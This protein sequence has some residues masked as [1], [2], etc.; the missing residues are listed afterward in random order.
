MLKAQL[1]GHMTTFFCKIKSKIKDLREQRGPLRSDYVNDE[2]M[3]LKNIMDWLEVPLNRMPDKRRHPVTG[4]NDLGDCE[5]ATREHKDSTNIM[6]IG[7]N[8]LTKKLHMEI[9]GNVTGGDPFMEHLSGAVQ[10]RLEE[11]KYK[12]QGIQPR[13][14][15]TASSRRRNGIDSPRV[16]RHGIVGGTNT[17]SMV[18]VH[19]N[20]DSGRMSTTFS[21]IGDSCHKKNSN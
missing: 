14:P 5:K 2:L 6:L 21:A 3:R 9:Q 18:D 11:L 16:R 20:G 15:T 19:C 10:K 1:I 17:A 4:L 7:L 12:S 8:K 13:P